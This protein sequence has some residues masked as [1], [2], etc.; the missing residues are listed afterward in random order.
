MDR[1]SQKYIGAPFPMRNPETVAFLIEV[2]EARHVK[3][4][5]EH[6]G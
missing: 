3:L 6:E 5:F 2:D 1:L 4:P